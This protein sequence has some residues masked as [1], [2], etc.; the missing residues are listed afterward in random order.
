MSIASTLGA[1]GVTALLTVGSAA[2][3][4][5]ASPAHDDDGVIWGTVVSTPDLK[6]RDEP[7]TAGRIVAKLPKGSEDRVDCATHG[8]VVHGDSLWY[9]LTGVGGW[10]SAAYVDTHGWHVPSCAEEDPC[11]KWKEAKDRDCHEPCAYSRH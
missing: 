8:T 5:A 10:V 2:S 9:W 1:V 4:T 7:S 3:A 6:V 11:P